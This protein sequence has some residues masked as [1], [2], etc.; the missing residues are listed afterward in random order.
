MMRQALWMHLHLAAAKSYTSNSIVQDI[1]QR[2]QCE[3]IL[4]FLCVLSCPLY[5]AGEE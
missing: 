5:G 2:E 1:L 3:L 4:R